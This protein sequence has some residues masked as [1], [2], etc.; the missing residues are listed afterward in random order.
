[1]Q[2]VTGQFQTQDGVSLF[3]QHWLPDGQT[4]AVLFLIHGL[5]EHSGRYAHVAA[6][7]TAR[8]YAVYAMDLRGHGQSPGLRG[9]I[10]SYETFLDDLA[11]YFT[12]VQAMNPNKAIF[13]L[14]HSMGGALTL[15]F[16]A[17]H[18]D[19]LAGAITSGALLTAGDSVSPILVALVDIVARVAGKLPVMTIE[20][21]ATSRDPAAVRAYDEDPYVY[22][23][24]IRARLGAALAKLMADAQSGLAGIT[25]PVLA[26]H[27]TADTL[28][29]P[30]SLDIIEREM[31]PAQRTCIRYEGLYHEIFNE[32]EKEQVMSDVA[33]WLEAHVVPA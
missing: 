21:G 12:E 18:Q 3:T 5:A 27:G 9:Y 24:R 15:S 23:G 19:Q 1:M 22:R 10:D 7:M 20:A 17:R 31:P 29:D 6:T 25:I 13:V 26:M 11:G 4:K 33:G 32:V 30:A 16:T 8:G 28:S 14:G 2:H